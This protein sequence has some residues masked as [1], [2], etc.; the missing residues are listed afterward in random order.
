LIHPSSYQ[1]GRAST[2]RDDYDRL[3]IPRVHRLIK[4][5]YD[6]LEPREYTDAEE[7]AITGHLVEAIDRVL[8]ET[9]RGG[10][11]F[12]SVHDDPPENE[13]RRRGRRRRTGRSRRRIDIRFDSSQ[14]SPR[15]RFRFECKRLSATYS[16]QRYL[17][18]E[19]LA[20]FIASEYARDD[21]R[22]GML[23]YVQTSG[24]AIWA[25]KIEQV[26]TTS[27]ADFAVRR[28]SQWRHEPV[29]QELVHTYRSGHSRGKG[30]RPIEIYHTLLRFT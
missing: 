21:V 10:M 30:R 8:D 9:S 27:P 24:E 13:P 15:T 1:P 17:G 28:V 29:I 16:A 19:G 4:L 14:V 25:N 12:Y 11:R 6:G 5:G 23:G 7:P 20:R 3:F 26:L 2:N 18:N 22:A